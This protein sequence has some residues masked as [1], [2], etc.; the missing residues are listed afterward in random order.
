LNVAGLRPGASQRRRCALLLFAAS[1]SA[2]GAAPFSH[3]IHLALKLE[4]VVCHTA[5]PRSTQ[6][7]DNLLP[8]RQICLEC[9]EDAAIPARIPVRISKFS[10][11]LHLRMGNIAPILA[12]AIDHNNY[13][14]PAGDIR[15]HLNTKNACEACHRGLEQSDR[16]TRAALPQMADCLVCHTQIE[17]PFSCQDCHPKDAQLAPASHDTPH[18]LDAH[19]SG[20][21]QLDKSTCAVCHGRVFQCMGCH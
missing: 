8:S 15:P 5:A 13:L 19:S 1:G 18:F 7:E 12:A 4:C 16:V 17:P 6:V 3:R 14:Q 11:E 20:R 21:L 9:H 2:W 10:H